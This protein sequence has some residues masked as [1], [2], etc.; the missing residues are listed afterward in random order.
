MRSPVRAL[1]GTGLQSKLPQNVALINRGLMKEYAAA[2]ADFETILDFL[3]FG[4]TEAKKEALYYGHGTDNAWDEMLALI[5]GSL[6]L[7][8]DIDKALLTARLT[9]DEKALLSQ[10]LSLRIHDKIPVPYLTRE[11]YFFRLPFYVD[12]RVLIPRSPIGELIEDQFSTWISESQVRRI[13]DLCTG[14]ACIAIALALAF[15]DALVDAS[16]L[17]TEALEVAAINVQRYQM[18]DQVTLIESNCWEK[19]PENKYD[20]IVSNPPYVSQTEM[21]T[22]PKEYLHEPQHALMADKEGLAIVECILAEAH[23]YLSSHGILVVEVGNSQTALTQAFPSLPFTWLEFERGGSGVF[24]LTAGQL[25]KHF[26]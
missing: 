22:L 12:Q 4:M 26:G 3:R 17:S 8:S 9:R 19:I 25:S 2:T 7:P 16:D 10:N 15:P 14:S 13:L 23:R 18:E 20:I 6:S 1:P 21:K 24:L 5:L 11:A